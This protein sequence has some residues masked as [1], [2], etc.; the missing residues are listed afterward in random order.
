MKKLTVVLSILVLTSCNQPTKK[1][2]TTAKQDLSDTTRV[3]G[4]EPTGFGGNWV[5]KKYLD[6]LLE[7]KSPIA[8]QDVVGIPVLTLPEETNQVA[9]VIWYFDE[10]EVDTVKRKDGKFSI[11]AYG[12]ERELTLSLENDILKT[13]E[14]EFIKFNN[15][16]TH[17]ENI[18][19]Q[20][21]FAGTYN[22]KGKQVEL[23]KE[24]KVIGIDTVS[25]YNVLLSEPHTIDLDGDQLRLESHSGDSNPYGFEFSA[26]TLTIY[27]LEAIYSEEYEGMIVAVKNGKVL[28]KMIKE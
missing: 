28:Y 23:T 14:G 19:E 4:G 25:G 2:K 15:D 17:R 21:L 24:G 16:E 26:D 5:N 22:W 27:E 3:S 9:W 1:N 12:D 7:T 11:H 13:E 8:S 18:A 20:F 10:A 6:K